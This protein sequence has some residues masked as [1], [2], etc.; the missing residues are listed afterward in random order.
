[1]LADDV[2]QFYAELVDLSKTYGATV[3][4]DV[5]EVDTPPELR[6]HMETVREAM[7]TLMEATRDALT[8]SLTLRR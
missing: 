2:A 8:A 5:W 7:D 4:D 1:M 3:L 6:T